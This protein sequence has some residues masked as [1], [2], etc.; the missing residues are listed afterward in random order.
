[1]YTLMIMDGND[2]NDIKYPDSFS[3]SIKMAHEN[4]GGNG[5]II[6]GGNGTHLIGSVSGSKISWRRGGI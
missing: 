2:I 1:M 6:F 4:D 5:F 3:E